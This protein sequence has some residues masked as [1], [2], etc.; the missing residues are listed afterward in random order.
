MTSYFSVKINKTQDYQA[1]QTYIIS[2]KVWVGVIGQANVVMNGLPGSPRPMLRLL[3]ATV[4]QGWSGTVMPTLEGYTF[5]PVLFHLHHR[6]R[7]SARKN[8]TGYRVFTISG[9]VTHDGVGLS[10]VVLNGLPDYI[11]TDSA[12]YYGATV[13]QGWYGTVTPVR[14]GYRFTPASLATAR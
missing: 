9:T 7:R 10:N 12:G 1:V 4:S 8:Y 5:H 11:A 6:H 14:I 13:Y 3:H 2:G